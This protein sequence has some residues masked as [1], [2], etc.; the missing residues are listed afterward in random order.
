METIKKTFK[1]TSEEYQKDLQNYEKKCND[2]SL[3]EEEK[4]NYII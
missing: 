2:I 4:K 3:A 1:R